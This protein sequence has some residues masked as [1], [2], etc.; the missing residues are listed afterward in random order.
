MKI[1][2]KTK[3]FISIITATCLLISFVIGP[4]AANAMTN[5]EA[6]SKYKQIFKDF[7]LP[8]N[9]GQITS[10]H[11]AGT[12]RVIINIQDLHCHPK[13]QKNI[14]NIIETFDKSYGVK[15]IYLEG[16]YGQVSTKWITEEIKKNTISNLLDKMLET[17]RL[18][19]AEYY[20]AMT[21]KTEIINGLEEKE[22]YLDNLKRFGSILENQEKINL[23]LNAMDESLLKLKEKYYT[24][25]QYKLEKLSNDYKEGKI[26]S[27]KY[28]ALLS[29]HIEKLGI[30]LSKYE[31][32]FS[33]IMLLEMQKKF[34]YSKITNELQNLV[35]VLKEQLPYNAYKLLLENTENFS[36]VDKLYVYLVQLAKAY[37][38]DLSVNFPNL[39]E[40]F[41]YIEFTQKINPLE[42]V[43]EED[44]LIQEINTMFSETQA[45]R[46]VVFLTSFSKYV[47]D[48]VSSKITSR[49]YEYYKDNIETYKKLWNE[50]VDN[51]VL[52][53]LE[54]YIAEADKFYKINTDRNI[55]FTDNMF[56]EQDV[57]GKL[58]NEVEA[59]GDVNKIIE[60]MKGVKEVDVVITGGFHSQTVTEILKNQGVSYIVITPN[61][62][63]GVK[64][65]EETYYEIAKEQSKIS[66]QA[67]ANLIASL[68]PQSQKTIF[69][70]LRNPNL[71]LNI[72]QDMA[73]EEQL[74]ILIKQLEYAKFLDSDDIGDIEENVT[75]ILRDNVD[76][77][78][79]D[80]ITPEMIKRLRMNGLEDLSNLGKIVEML[81]KSSEFAESAFVVGDI[82]SGIIK[83]FTNL[84]AGLIADNL[85]S[86]KQDILSK[87][88]R[89]IQLLPEVQ[90]RYSQ[91][92]FTEYELKGAILE[93]LNAED[94]NINL[95]D[96]EILNQIDEQVTKIMEELADRELSFKDI[97]NLQ[98]TCS[99]IRAYSAYIQNI[100]NEKL[101]EKGT[102]QDKIKIILEEFGG[103]ENLDSIQATILF[104]LCRDNGLF[105]EMIDLYEKTGDAA[106]EFKNSIEIRELYFVAFNK[107]GSFEKTIE[108]L[109]ILGQE[110]FDEMNG[111]LYAT[112]GKAY[113][114]RYKQAK[115]KSGMYG[116]LGQAYRM[117]YKEAIESGRLD[118]A[119]LALRASYESYRKGFEIDHYYYPGINAVYRLRELAEL[120]IDDKERES[121][122]KE[123]E[124]LAAL[125]YYSTEKAGGIRSGDYWTLVTMVEAMTI[126]GMHTAKT[127]FSSINEILDK[128]FGF[129]H[130]TW[131]IDTTLSNLENLLS[132]KKENKFSE[133]EKDKKDREYKDPKKDI[134]NLNKIINKLYM[135][136][137]ELTL[138]EYKSAVKSE[139]KEKLIKQI[140]EIISKTI[141][142]SSKS[143]AALASELFSILELGT[144]E[145]GIILTRINSDSDLRNLIEINM[146]IKEELSFEN[147]KSFIDKYLIRSEESGETLF[148][149]AEQTKREEF[150][151]GLLS[152]CYRIPIN[153]LHDSVTRHI[154]GN[155]KFGG[156]LQE[157]QLAREDMNIAIQIL[158]IFG[159]DTE[160][161]LDSFMETIDE[162]IRIQYRNDD[163]K[164]ENLKSRGHGKFDDII[165]QL[166]ELTASANNT[167]SRTNIMLDFLL[168]VGDCRQHGE[169][170][171]VFFDVWKEMRLAEYYKK[172]MENP[173]LKTVIYRKIESLQRKQLLTME[174]L[175]VGNIAMNSLYSFVRD[176][177]G[178][179]IYSE[180]VNDIEEHVLNILV[181]F[182]RDGNIVQDS[183]E[184]ADSF[185]Q[186]EYKFGGKD[187]VKLGKDSFEYVDGKLRIKAGTVTAIDPKTGEEIESPVYLTAPKAPY[188]GFES[189]VEK[190]G[191]HSEGYHRDTYGVLFRGI[192]SIKTI[193]SRV[194]DITDINPLDLLRSEKKSTG[195]R[196][197]VSKESTETRTIMDNFLDLILK[198]Y[199][200]A[201][202]NIESETIDGI[203]EPLL[204]LVALKDDMSQTID[205]TIL[206][207]YALHGRQDFQTFTEALTEDIDQT[208]ASAET[209]HTSYYEDIRDNQINSSESPVID[210]RLFDE[211]FN[212][213]AS[214]LLDCLTPKK[215]ETITE[216]HFLSPTEKIRLTVFDI[217][218]G[219]IEQFYQLVND[220]YKVG[221][222]EIKKDGTKIIEARKYVEQNV[223][224]W[225][226]SGY[227][228]KS[229]IE[230][231]ERGEYVL[232][233][234]DFT[235]YG[236]EQVDQGKV[237][238]AATVIVNTLQVP[239]EYLINDIN[240]YGGVKV[241]GKE[242][243][244]GWRKIQAE[245]KRF[246]I[247]LQTDGIA[248]TIATLKYLRNHK[249][250]DAHL[251]LKLIHA[252]W[253]VNNV[254]EPLSS[255]HYDDLSFDEKKHL[256]VF[257]KD[258]SEYL[259]VEKDPTISSILEQLEKEYEKASSIETAT[260]QEEALVSQDEI[261]RRIAS[262]N[263]A[264][265]TFEKK[266][267]MGYVITEDM[268]V[269]DKE[270]KVTD[271]IIPEAIRKYIF[272][273]DSN[274]TKQEYPP[275]Y[276]EKKIGCVITLQT[277]EDGTPDFYIAG[278]FKTDYR[279]I[280][281]SEVQS[282][283]PDMFD[284]L[285]KVPGLADIIDSGK[286]IGASKGAL[287]SMVAMSELGYDTS[288]E[289]S[290]ETSWIDEKTGKPQKQ[291]K[292]AGK[293][294]YLVLDSEGQYYM[295]NIDDQTGYPIN[296][297]PVT[298]EQNLSEYIKLVRSII[299]SLGFEFDPE[300]GDV[301][302]R[303]YKGDK[304]T[305]GGYPKPQA[306]PLDK[307]MELVN[308]RNVEVRH[309][310]FK[311][312]YK[313]DNGETIID[314]Y[315]IPE[316][317]NGIS[318]EEMLRKIESGEI[319]S[320]LTLTN[321]NLLTPS[322]NKKGILREQLK[323]KG[324]SNAEELI[325]H[326][327]NPEHGVYVCQKLSTADGKTDYVISSVDSEVDS[328][329]WGT[330]IDTVL[331]ADVIQGI[332]G[333]FE[334][335]IE[336]GTGAGHLAATMSKLDGVE[337]IYVTDISPYALV[338]SL[339]NILKTLE[340][341]DLESA[342]QAKKDLIKL[343]PVLGPGIQGLDF[344]EHNMDMIVVNPPYIDEP[345]NLRGEN[346]LTA[347]GG[348]KFLREILEN[349]KTLLNSKNPDAQAILSV[350]STTRMALE[351]YLADLGYD[352]I[353][354]PIGTPQ[355]APLKVPYVTENPK[356]IQWLLDEG[357]AYSE[358]DY[359][360]KGLEP[361]SHALVTYRV[362]LINSK[363]A[364]NARSIALERFNQL[365]PTRGPTTIKELDSALTEAF[366]GNRGN[367]KKFLQDFSFGS[368]IKYQIWHSYLSDLG[369]LSLEEQIKLL[370]AVIKIVEK[371]NYDKKV[372][373]LDLRKL[374]NT[375][376]QKILSLDVDEIVSGLNYDIENG[377]IRV[378]LSGKKYGKGEEQKDVSSSEERVSEILSET[379]S[380]NA[381]SAIIEKDGY[382]K[383]IKSISDLK[384]AID[385]SKIHNFS[386][387]AIIVGGID[388]EVTKGKLLDDVVVDENGKNV[389][390]G[391]K[392]L[393]TIA[394]KEDLDEIRRYSQS[395]GISLSMHVFAFTK[396]VMVNGEKKQI[397]PNPSFNENWYEMFKMQIDIA[398]RLGI[399][400]VVTHAINDMSSKNIA[401]WMMLLKY[402]AQKGISIDFENDQVFLKE[403]EKDG[404]T[405]NLF[406][407]A[408]K[409]GYIDYD[410]FIKFLNAIRERL[411]EE[412]KRYIGVTLDTTKA[413]S[414]FTNAAK[415]RQEKLE[416]LTFDNLMEYI[417]KVINAGYKINIVHLSQFR[418]DK[419][420][421]KEVIDGNEVEVFYDKSSISTDGIITPENL[422]ILLN[423]LKTHNPEVVI[424]QETMADVVSPAER[425]TAV[426][427]IS[428]RI[429]S[430]AETETEAES[431][432]S[433][434]TEV[435]EE[436]TKDA[437]LPNRTAQKTAIRLI[438][439]SE[440]AEELIEKGFKLNENLVVV[441]DETR[442]AE[443]RKQGINALL[444]ETSHERGGVT[445][446]ELADGIKVRV[447]VKEGGI[448]FCVR[449]S[450]VIKDSDIDKLMDM[451]V[452]KMKTGKKIKGLENIK[453]ISYTANS[454]EMDY[455]INMMKNAHTDSIASSIEPNYRYSDKEK[456][457]FKAIAEKTGMTTFIISKSKA[458][459][460]EKLGGKYN[461]VVSYTDEEDLIRK[462]EEKGRT[463][464]EF[465]LDLSSKSID[466]VELKKILANIQSIRRKTKNGLDI[467]ITLELDS[468]VLQ[469]LNDSLDESIY[470]T[471]GIIPLVSG[472]QVKMI[473]GKKKVYK[474]EE[475][476]K[477]D[478][479]KLKGNDIV[480]ILVDKETVK[481]FGKGLLENI[482][483]LLD[484]IRTITEMTPERKYKKGLNAAMSTKFDYTIDEVENIQAIFDVLSLDMKAS[485]IKEVL[486]SLN[487]S[488][489][490]NEAQ[491]Y[492]KYQ[493]EKGNYEELLGFIRGVA[494]N[495]L[496]NNIPGI[497]PIDKEKLQEKIKSNEVQAILILTLQAMMTGKSFR[498]LYEQRSGSDDLTA[499][500]YLS[501]IR[502]S[503]HSRLEEI[504]KDNEY[505]IDKP[506]RQT[507]VDFT[508]IPELLMDDFNKGA[509]VKEEVKISVI[510][511]RS[512]LAAA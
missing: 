202:K 313:G 343:I 331:A 203:M 100:V 346:D 375:D 370:A 151:K 471:Y 460:R 479:E 134:E 493:K 360:E 7:M 474:I 416:Q 283:I 432:K 174:S 63:D 335:V 368:E 287:V 108:R 162:I 448:I 253:A 106:Q 363:K 165:K 282:K 234:K 327:Y 274:G 155:Y 508:G 241:D 464:N 205:S 149:Q 89:I 95:S 132:Q 299:M 136:K 131:E 475:M 250:A 498:E 127:G 141:E 110:N 401:A 319:K 186:D 453:N 240:K 128:A 193:L 59:K 21:G 506:T 158:E 3:K 212:P 2:I 68:S 120:T 273:V 324:V 102:N 456:E 125:V 272:Q 425:T 333:R 208:L 214:A 215:R 345:E 391:M 297:I 175:V 230:K 71:S 99:W 256:F 70:L 67:L 30:D 233:K 123:A 291:V 144:E 189:R 190:G 66:F 435:I 372:I 403:Q 207:E 350:S 17:G 417:E 232:E 119:I 78:N 280:N 465:V 197:V 130:H 262:V 354:E 316:E 246:L 114:E 178:K 362:R 98:L 285:M 338:A 476:S 374:Q 204:K 160:D 477:E 302:Y 320:F 437:I 445:I 413:I 289:V 440:A 238:L 181:E 452:E 295:V 392:W 312:F 336:L 150:T 248:V 342:E 430:K 495:T 365:N 223:Q 348:T 40:Y 251:A 358:S 387:L 459:E 341:G 29:K 447:K 485:N 16:A 317:F 473:K 499:A 408:R 382:P 217:Q 337:N 164:L 330:M 247:D 37:N 180:D 218:E 88:A 104:Y 281:K 418:L 397:L 433:K 34:D 510:A 129:V 359:K 200:D 28:F 45:Q 140:L 265:H 137:L 13:V 377:T 9:Y 225:S 116:A 284:N 461:F 126:N 172:A 301:V 219:K 182:D 388:T 55:Y 86:E 191:I 81:D 1:F 252:G 27:K 60:N 511:V 153:S 497:L 111:E 209:F 450:G 79:K 83:I 376:L 501:A 482:R 293:D 152:F 264:R 438:T 196:T 290:I 82:F 357:M 407:K 390:V 163:L 489:F 369:N 176:A 278:N 366:R 46:E 381:S 41:G 326:L 483:T 25:R 54:E 507:A 494:M 48:Y 383:E 386:E 243:W 426:P 6:T 47:R 472:K 56:K 139:D 310:L 410:S 436:A 279:E 198:Y 229:G 488:I 188:A 347:Y 143:R 455:I 296:Y 415:T 211:K 237:E 49:D 307:I 325:D 22:P 421:P 57:L 500:Q 19:G 258:V 187:K 406:A 322:L 462:I 486:D 210:T 94:S 512:M 277:K 177:N 8:Y 268:M 314:Y 14:S 61:V 492:I 427:S 75:K 159:L 242:D 168:G 33:Y 84:P 97:D 58:E 468:D 339:S 138:A 23:I 213:K 206:N 292:P 113:Y 53:L 109:S 121:M 235:A 352:Y 422:E 112:L 404:T 32:T 304:Y 18:T 364:K 257:L 409:E 323:Q 39:D 73:V 361:Y 133:Y 398:E 227:L 195:T 179:L 393:Q 91:F 52:S 35:L 31:N 428:E 224:S 394:S 5:E 85:E 166:K 192:P 260:E 255:F 356:W 457:S 69:D 332:S 51:R 379:G 384:D 135:K 221:K 43:E 244:S 276:Y 504:L 183:V 271:V 466:V 171:Q 400:H 389:T 431:I 396:D 20:S 65:A 275:S 4:T 77:K 92:L 378:R 222:V 349:L 484:N 259:Q 107:T 118:E 146:E 340:S 439:S 399:K 263:P 254:N 467:S 161:D 11:Y 239:W 142:Y 395:Q 270:G 62:T 303:G 145:S 269:R 300:T 478:I 76:E 491:V 199:R 294:A 321:E 505:K 480:G 318:G 449:K 402:S 249:I 443:L 469:A 405:T 147:V 169:I 380:L 245:R 184:L 412:E 122:L 12:D 351:R 236:W 105:S 502:D 231:V 385:W 267:I 36:K 305:E 496:A 261:R 44:Q 451:L 216:R 101:L 96:D 220:F 115:D 42:L 419:Q 185:Y 38:L 298:E 487:T 201:T 10:A 420:M 170:K 353:F 458:E 266:P 311:M 367:I 470:D 148:Q 411:T 74:A 50:Y 228:S 309:S 423:T 463:E 87:E 328:G 26:T 414:S 72:E 429:V 441:Q 355:N 103:Y 124:N 490:S 167:D 24:K 424:L 315:E 64:L 509:A 373:S 80:K 90:R 286:V 444:F 288:K 344:L 117:R 306:L 434:V 173:E 334:N 329:V 157:M 454:E 226:E 371:E 308:K 156:G 442:S 481:K 154:S 446:G 15:K 93:V 503:L 194:L